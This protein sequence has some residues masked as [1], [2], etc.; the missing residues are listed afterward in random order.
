MNL[1]A[2]TKFVAIPNHR[3][4]DIKFDEPRATVYIYL[5]RIE[6]VYQ[7]Q[8]GRV[9]NKYWDKTELIVRDL[10]YGIWRYAYLVFDKHRVNC[11]VCGVLV[12]QLDWIEPWQ[13]Y[14]NRL[15]DAV[16]FA[17]R[18]VRALKAIAD[19][20]DMDWRAVKEIDKENLKKRLDPPDF[21]GVER[22]A[23]DEIALEQ[24]QSYA[25]MVL[26]FDKH[27]VLWVTKGRTKESLD[28]F[29]KMLGK[30]GCKK[31]KA[32]A[33]DMWDPY[34]E[35]TKEHTDADI[36]YDPFHIISNFGKVIDKVRNIEA[37]KAKDASKK[38]MMRSRVQSIS[39]CRTRRT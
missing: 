12:E 19:A 31:I 8:C 16:A 13:R 22:I 34:R 36:V 24:G 4:R 27:R 33:M 30:D 17:C 39:S 21:S 3:V 38:T 23:I 25:T 32:A 9:K 35:S 28:E 10:S 5:E 6:N 20:F 15:S 7:C 1:D 29:Y 26:D 11:D 2:I 37:N 18:E 14:T